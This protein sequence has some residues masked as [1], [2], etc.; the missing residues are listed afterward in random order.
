M[1]MILILH[2]MLIDYFMA[3]IGWFR[4]GHKVDSLSIKV[5]I[6]LLTNVQGEEQLTVRTSETILHLRPLWRPLSYGGH[7]A[8]P[9]TPPSSPILSRAPTPQKPA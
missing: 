9:P 4:Y 2:L 6:L 8:A 1:L 3:F 7:Y 5:F